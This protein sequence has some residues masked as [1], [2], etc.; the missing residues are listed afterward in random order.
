MSEDIV[1]AHTD[2]RFQSVNEGNC[3][4]CHQKMNIIT[5]RVWG[6]PIRG[7]FHAFAEM[8]CSNTLCPFPD[9]ESWEDA[10][11]MILPKEAET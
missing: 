10:K 4:F 2:F 6:G 3:P 11:N 8:V 1:C 5:R 9:A 7:Y